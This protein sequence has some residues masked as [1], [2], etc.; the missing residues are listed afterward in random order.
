[1][2]NFEYAI[3]LERDG[4]AYYHDCAQKT[5]DPAAKRM[6]NELANDEKDHE[7]YL[8]EMKAGNFV[9][10]RTH[11]SEGVKNVFAELTASSNKIDGGDDLKSIL[12][13]GVEAERKSVELYQDFADKT[14]NPEEK[15]FWTHLVSI[16][17]KHEKVLNMTL[18]FMDQP[19]NILEDAEFLFN[20]DERI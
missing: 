4:Y 5:S 13:K 19:S 9:T 10:V 18:E 14:D 15:K 17:Q 20:D 6:L 8:N 1:M 12:A 11:I 7:A 16:E 2:D 3:Q